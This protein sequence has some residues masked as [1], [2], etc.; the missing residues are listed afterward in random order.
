ME[1]CSL[2]EVDELGNAYNLYGELI[3]RTTLRPGF[4]V[5]VPGWQFPI[6]PCLYWEAVGICRYMNYLILKIENE[7]EEKRKEVYKSR[8]NKIYN[9]RHKVDQINEINNQCVGYM[10]YIKVRVNEFIS[11]IESN[12]KVA[13]EDDLDSDFTIKGLKIN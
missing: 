6:G 7:K 4:Y 3:E 11:Q 13:D 2:F 9:A 12:I 5:K 10:D 1:L 8:L